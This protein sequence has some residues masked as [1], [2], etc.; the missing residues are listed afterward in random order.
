MSGITFHITFDDGTAKT[1][2]FERGR[3]KLKTLRLLE[4]AQRNTSWDTLIPAIAGILGLTEAEADE[5]TLDDWEAIV[6]TMREATK[7]VGTVPPESA[8]PSE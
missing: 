5:I 3:I 8:P 7:E 2:V 6:A 4:R 1:V